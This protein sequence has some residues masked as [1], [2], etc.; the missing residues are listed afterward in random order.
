MV[1]YLDIETTGLR[2][3]EHAITIIGGYDGSTVTQLIQGVNLTQS[4][5]QELFQGHD[6]IATFNGKLFDIPFIEEYFPGCVSDDV[7]HRDLMRSAGLVGWFGSLK[8]IEKRLGISRD[9][10]VNNGLQ[11][12]QLWED[13]KNGSTSALKKLLAYNK[14]DIINLEILEQKIE[15]ELARL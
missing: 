12:I 8:S 10:G 14:E 9:S 13:Y 6:K 3:K 11:A 2:K 5:V 15:E 7:I 1:L 4:S